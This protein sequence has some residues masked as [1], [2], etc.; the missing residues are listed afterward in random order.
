MYGGLELAIA[1]WLGMSALKRER[2]RDALVL[3]AVLYA[4]LGLGRG[5]GMALD[6]DVTATSWRII[7][8]EAF[9]ALGSAFGAW[10]HGRL[11]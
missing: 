11:K 7:A 10:A 4:G 5:V 8:A 3:S 9:A 1:A 6:V 2:V